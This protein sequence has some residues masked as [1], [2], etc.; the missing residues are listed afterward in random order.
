MMSSLD[1]EIERFKLEINLVEYAQSQG[2]SLDK[3]ES[4]RSSAVLRREADDDKI[5]VATG[6]DGHGIYFSVRDDRDNGSIVDFVQKRK[7]LNLGQ[8]RQEL[9]P[10]ITGKSFS[11]CPPAFKPIAIAKDREQV[12]RAHSKTLPSPTHPYLTGDRKIL[13]STLADPRF[14]Y[15][16]RQDS[17][18]NAIFPHYDHDGLAGYEIKNSG[19][20]GFAPGGVKSVW[21][22]SNLATAACVVVTES[23]IDALSH[24]QL[25]SDLGL[26]YVSFGGALSDRQKDLFKRLFQKVVDRGASV[27]L[28]TDSDK[29]GDLYA[30][31]LL[32]LAPKGLNIQRERPTCKD[33]NEDLSLI[34]SRST[35]PEQQIPSA[36]RSR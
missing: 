19:F 14:S 28:A 29:Q 33:W 18:G 5:V 10:F 21:H 3:R 8:V 2:Y 1:R 16:V 11:Y 6:L 30:D 12:I 34:S 31:E 4:S 7:G 22:S 13:G 17:Q 26:A 27:V 25:T 24:A 36:Y 35:Q 9:R 20:T 15:V 32:S 23:A